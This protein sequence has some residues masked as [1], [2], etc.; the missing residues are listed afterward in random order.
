MSL[1]LS[2]S[3]FRNYEWERSQPAT[4]VV[5]ALIG[6]PLAT[7]TSKANS[8]HLKIEVLGSTWY[9]NLSPGRIT[10]QSPEAGQR[11]R[12]DT[13]IGVELATKP[14]DVAPPTP[15]QEMIGS[16]GSQS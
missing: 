7:G 12:Y 13:M 16:L 5:P 10:L 2:F 3:L 4:V 1:P 6:L 14:P 9:T 15:Y 11:V 8:A